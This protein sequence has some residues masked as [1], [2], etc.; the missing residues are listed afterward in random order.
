MLSYVSAALTG[1]LLAGTLLDRRVV[2]LLMFSAFSS[3]FGFVVNDLCDAEL[4][5]VAGVTRNPLSTG[6]LSMGRGISFALLLLLSSMV[7]LSFLSLRSRLL[8]LIVVFLYLTYS[9]LVRAKARPILDIAYHGLCLATLA[10]MGY[11]EHGR[12]DAK[13]LLFASIVF[14]LSSMSQV[15]QEVRDYETD[16]A[17]IM[18]TVTLLGKRR[19]L[20]LCLALFISTFPL[21]FILFLKGAIPI[22]MSILLPLTYFIIAPIFQAIR[23]EE[24][25]RRMLTAIKER[26]LIMIALIIATFILDRLYLLNTRR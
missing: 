20:I 3:A 5:R 1:S 24:Y 13:C 16:R 11:M 10:A 23:N 14:L 12:I 6:E 9:C 19:S 7:P 2:W 22:E 25:E 15:L 8:G 21:V 18:T 26:R 4:D 17:K